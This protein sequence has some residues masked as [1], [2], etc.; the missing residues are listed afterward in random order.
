MANTV[1]F[2]PEPPFVVVM[3]NSPRAERIVAQILLAE[4]IGGE[5]IAAKKPRH[6]SDP[7]E[8]PAPFGGRRWLL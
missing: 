5:A 6:R 2:A 8:V 4:G 1:G 7:S 3:G